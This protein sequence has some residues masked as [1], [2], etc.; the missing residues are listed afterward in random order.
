MVRTASGYGYACQSYRVGG[1]WPGTAFDQNV[2][3]GSRA[4]LRPL[5]AF[6]S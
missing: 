4:R 6:G 1:F 3:F 5:E 2:F